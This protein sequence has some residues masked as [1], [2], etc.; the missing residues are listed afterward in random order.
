MRPKPLIL[1]VLNVTPDSFS[2][3]GRFV[4]V[5]KAI[6]FAAAMW[7]EG[8]DY[9]DVGGESTRPGAAPVSVEEE[10]R[11]V[12]PV[13]ERLLDDVGARVSID[14][15]KFEVAKACADLG[16][17][18]INDV[19]GGSDPRLAKLVAETGL[20]VILMHMRGTPETMQRNLVYENG[21][22]SE[23]KKFLKERVQ[24]FCDAGV[25]RERIWID[26]GIGFGKTL[27]QNLDLLRRLDEFDGIAGR[28]AIGTSR[29]SFLALILGGP[30]VPIDRREPGTLA[31]N[32][33]AYLK[34]ASVF[35][36]HD[37]GV[38]RH[39]ITTWEAIDVSE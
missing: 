29:K 31:S 9:I 38:F 21:A 14:T 28:V 35:R 25:R 15:R 37:V 10:L 13:V 17:S 32:L 34:G 4:D 24:L 6:K 3:G 2:D 12:L 1:G 36:V 26:P 22:I 19:S 39:A 11:R 33:W 20:D 5:E 30:N 16:V 23:V 7:K 8:A 18:V 27:D